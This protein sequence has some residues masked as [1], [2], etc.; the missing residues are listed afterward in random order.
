MLIEVKCERRAEIDGV[1]IETP[2]KNLNLAFNGFYKYAT[3]KDSRWARVRHNGYR[4]MASDT[5]CLGVF[6]PSLARE[7]FKRI[8][9]Y[10]YSSGHQ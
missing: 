9:T 4:D 2:D 10:Q 8:L 3:N 6:N 1:S 5:E 7:H